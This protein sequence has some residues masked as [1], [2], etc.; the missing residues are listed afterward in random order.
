MERIVVVNRWSEVADCTVIVSKVNKRLGVVV[1]RFRAWLGPRYSPVRITLRPPS[2]L[3]EWLIDLMFLGWQ[4]QWIIKERQES[5]KRRIRKGR[6][7]CHIHLLP[8]CRVNSLV[9]SAPQSSM[10]QS[11]NGDHL[12]PLSTNN[13]LTHS[14]TPTP[15][16]P[17]NEAWTLFPV[18][19]PKKQKCQGS[20]L[21]IESHCG[22]TRSA[23]KIV[24]Q[25]ECV[26][27]Y[28]YTWYTPRDYIILEAE[29]R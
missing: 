18:D 14:L 16:Q 28:L 23:S 20:S 19:R 5:L 17:G 1:S 3:I 24:D 12:F 2:V 8:T 11:Q 6:G 22:A 10:F 7:Y 26:L 4:L 25:W 13:T 15:C 21:N 29:S 27:Y 9:A